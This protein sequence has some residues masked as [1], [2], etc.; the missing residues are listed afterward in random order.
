MAGTAASPRAAATHVGT[1]CA[2]RR[3]ASVVSE[4]GGRTHSG[5]GGGRRG[6]DVNIEALAVQNSGRV[7]SGCRVRLAME[8]V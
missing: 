6:A 2:K 4:L 5:R 7:S 1:N 8:L 3:L